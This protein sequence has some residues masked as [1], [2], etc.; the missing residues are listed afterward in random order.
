MI[1]IKVEKQF[2]SAF[3]ALCLLVLSALATA[4]SISEA[5]Q[6]IKTGDYGRALTL[7]SASA[8]GGDPEGMLGMGRIYRNGLGVER[9]EAKAIEWFT[10][11]VNTLNA[12]A[13]QGDPRAFAILGVMFNKGV[14]YN[15]DKAKAK[16][17]FKY[18]FD[19]AQPKALQG[20]ADSQHL[21]G[22]LYSSGKGVDKDAYAGADWLSKAGEG[23]NETAIKMLI[24][25]FDCGCRGLPKDAEKVEYWRAKLIA[26]SKPSP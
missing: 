11:A 6:A 9:D 15:Q 3:I 5:E 24:H 4:G 22:M 17:Y 10:K 20:D 19:L 8:Q 12:S 23:G 14:G 26:N 1:S 13:H 21:I 18:A 16:E 25:I 2:F 7:F